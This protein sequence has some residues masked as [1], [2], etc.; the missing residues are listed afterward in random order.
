M[1]GIAIL[2]SGY[3]QL[4][5]GLPS[6]HWQIVVYLA[7]FS[8]LTHLT[9]LT[10]L[11]PYL[12][13][14]HLLLLLRLLFMAAVLVLLGCALLPTGN[15]RWLDRS[16]ILDYSVVNTNSTLVHDSFQPGIPAQCFYQQLSAHEGYSSGSSQFLSMIV[17]LFVLTS[18]YLIKV[19][20]LSRKGSLV[21]R[22][23]IRSKPGAW[24]KGR[25]HR[26]AILHSR[27]STR[28][29][30]VKLSFHPIEVTVF[31]IVLA[32]FDLVESTLWEVS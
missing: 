5:C 20:K 13:R 21:S 8:S 32:I 3:S 2:A 12:H 14:Y 17:S 30:R 16:G 31:V 26:Q 29:N 15:S 23:Y 7:W 22:Q 27:A 24:W 19:V 11:R 18:S 25:L 1:T 28:A 4:T 6:Y 10:V 9:T